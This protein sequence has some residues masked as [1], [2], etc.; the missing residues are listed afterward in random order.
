MNLE[1]WTFSVFP[2]EICKW[3]NPIQ[4]VIIAWLWKHKNEEWVCWPSQELLSEECG[5]SRRCLNEHLIILENEGVIIR[6]KQR[7][8]GWKNA[9]TIY[10]I[11]LVPV[12][13]HVHM[14]SAPR[15]HGVVRHVHTNKNHNITKSIEL[16]IAKKDSLKEFREFIIEN[17]TVTSKIVSHLFEL[18]WTP[19]KDET[20]E[21][22]RKWITDLA[23]VN[24]L[25]PE[26]L[27]AISERWKL[28]WQTVPRKERKN[29][30]ATFM[31]NP[32]LP[33]NKQKWKSAR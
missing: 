6:T 25:T 28:Y 2:T 24:S 3:R 27:L 11:P 19:R 30:K 10:E 21:T 33:N 8:E 31:N 13:H 5:I 20:I 14:D 18:W 17:Q 26:Q 16:D 7:F 23:L 1:R 22:F 9:N 12:V 4:Q 15:A 29:W 32:E